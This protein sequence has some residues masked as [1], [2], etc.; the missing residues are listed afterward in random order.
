MRDIVVDVMS[1][2][3]IGHDVRRDASLYEFGVDVG[4]VSN[5]ADRPRF[6]ILN[7]LFDEGHRLLEF[8]YNMFHVPMFE[9]A[10]CPFRVDLNNQA[11]AL[12]HRDCQGLGTAHST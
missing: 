6:I 10:H 3:L 1:R 12:I 11:N 2:C 7:R 8:I 9:P 4:R 5:E